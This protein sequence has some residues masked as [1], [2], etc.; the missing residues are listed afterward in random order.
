MTSGSVIVPSPL[1]GEVVELTERRPDVDVGVHLTLTSESAS[2]RWEPLT[3]GKGLRDPDGFFW[4]R[5][6][7]VRRHAPVGSV[8]RELRAQVEH[9]M[10]AG[11]TI[12]HL[13]HHMGVALAPEFLA[14]TVGVAREMGIT[15]L[16]P[17]DLGAYYEAVR[18]SATPP[19]ILDLR[20]ELVADELVIGEHFAMGY[21][22]RDRPCREV[23]EE[24]FDAAQP[25]V[26]FLS[27]HCSNPGD[28]AEVH[29]GSADW[30]VSE[31]EL[32]GDPDFATWVDGSG[33]QLGSV[34]SLV[35]RPATGDR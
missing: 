1:F 19:E 25:G 31:Y 7:D 16:L 34:R 18:L 12:S 13:D 10:R 32:F 28:I 3:D 29:P 23:Y 5:T 4:R 6:V 26:T 24:I 35:R 17:I 9:A 15:L 14:A 2:F 21:A 20:A 22:E 8:E 27:L 33:V 11:L 30:R